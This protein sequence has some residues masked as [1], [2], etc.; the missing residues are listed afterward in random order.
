MA[1]ETADDK[2]SLIANARKIHTTELGAMRIAKNLRLDFGGK[3]SEA[4][5]FCVKKICSPNCQISRR[6]KNWYCRV[7]GIEI[8]VNA[9]SFTIITAH[10]FERDAK[11]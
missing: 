10:P 1:N 2:E 4:A 8:T 11:R 3:K 7:D 5:D 6:G 9:H